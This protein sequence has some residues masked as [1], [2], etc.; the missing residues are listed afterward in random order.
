[1]DL[2]LHTIICSTRPTRRGPAVA[3]WFHAFAQQHGK[4]ESKLVDLAS[5][6]L[7]VFD[8]PEHPAR[9]RYQHEHTKAWSASVA[10]ADAFAFV[11]P[12]YNFSPSPAMLNALDYLFVEWAFK[13]AG[14]VSYGGVSGGLRAAQMVKLTLTALNMMPVPS[15]VPIPNFVSMIEGDR[16]KANNLIEKSAATMLDELARWASALK[17][18]R[19]LSAPAGRP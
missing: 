9:Q 5:F 3:N 10:A 19:Q 15:G 7:P 8:E 13:P 16:F 1:M 11:M 2:K 17:A 12:E 14:L 6:N 4:F 18:A